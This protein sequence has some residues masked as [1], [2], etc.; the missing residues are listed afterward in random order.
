MK[1]HFK[2]RPFEALGAGAGPVSWFTMSDGWYWFTAG[3]HDLLRHPGGEGVD[4]YVD[5]FWE[6]VLAFAPNVL[7]P[8]PADLVPFVASREQDWADSESDEAWA[9]HLWHRGHNLFVGYLAQ[10]PTIRGW[11]V[12]SEKGDEVTIAW[13]HDPGATRLWADEPEGQ[14]TVAAETFLAAV[15]DFDARW[16]AA[17]RA[18]AGE[19]AEPGREALLKEGA[20]REPALARALAEPPSPDYAD[21]DVV[22][23]GAAEL[24]S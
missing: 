23:A 22:R 6:D 13:Q 7:R 10:P 4:Y 15:R 9:A 12:R 20:G 17:M 24:L 2:L 21:L 18:R 8:V 3:G 1:F 14:V 5:T 19:V 16:R 11:R